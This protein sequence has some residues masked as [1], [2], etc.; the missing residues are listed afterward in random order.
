[1]KYT[2]ITCFIYNVTS[3]FL[4]TRG[5]NRFET[6]WPGEPDIIDYFKHELLPTCTLPGIPFSELSLTCRLLGCDIHRTLHVAW[7][8]IE[9][10]F[11]YKWIFEKNLQLNWKTKP[12]TR[13]Q[14]TLKSTTSALN[15]GAC[16]YT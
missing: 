16:T 9:V 1:M 5:S 14:G 11:I 8:E 3:Q 12:V 7:W 15:Y 2:W 4:N 6:V 10:C 13:A